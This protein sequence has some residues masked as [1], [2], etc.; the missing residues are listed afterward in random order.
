MAA[1]DDVVPAVLDGG[2]F[3]ATP[4]TAGG[5]QTK[6]WLD[7]DGSGFVFSDAARRL[8]L[9]A[10]GTGFAVAPRFATRTMP[11]ADALR[12]PLLDTKQAGD[13]PLLQGFDGQLGASWFAGRRWIFDYP[14]ATLHCNAPVRSS[15]W[16]P[17]ELF[18]GKYPRVRI[19]IAGAGVAASFDTAASV[20]LRKGVLPRF[21]DALPA[22]RATSFV[23]RALFERWQAE[24][25]DWPVV[26][27]AGT[28][29]IDAIRVASV[30]I[31][32]WPLGPQWFTTR[33]GDDV[34]EGDAIELKI[35]ASAFLRYAAELDYP[36]MRL[37]LTA[38]S[39]T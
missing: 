26:R 18:G 34:F 33:P 37:G 39:Q 12:L 7:T 31:G 38:R 5:Q 25:A 24:H 22:L 17:V 9:A 28:A 29:G 27:N 8:Q 2:R 6:W 19:E 35:G 16:V 1:P 21:G 13:D 11:A 30:T 10:D 15:S 32:P 14:N 4:R 3:F 36:R 23:K 20:A